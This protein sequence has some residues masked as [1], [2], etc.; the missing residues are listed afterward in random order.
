[1][2]SQ[3]RHIRNCR[4]EVNEHAHGSKGVVNFGRASIEGKDVDWRYRSKIKTDPYQV[5]HDDLFAAIRN[6]VSYS[7]AENGAYSTLTS[8]MG[9]MASYSGKPITWDQA[10]NSQVSLMPTAFTWDT[11]PQS[12][13]DENGEY[14]IATPG[15]TTV[16]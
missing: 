1:M 2:F 3:C 8:I 6:D 5:E 12:M 4:N 7:E 14:A 15:V 11:N 16:V 9:R 10:L 13:P